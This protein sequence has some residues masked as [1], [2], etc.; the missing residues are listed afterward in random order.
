MFKKDKIII[1]KKKTINLI[2]W[3]LLWYNSSPPSVEYIAKLLTIPRVKIQNIKVKS[4][5]FIF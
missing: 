3:L 5:D 4:K 2:I 1:I